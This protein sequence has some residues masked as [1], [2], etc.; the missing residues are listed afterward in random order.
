VNAAPGNIEH[1]VAYHNQIGKF[2]KR[3]TLHQ[4]EDLNATIHFADQYAQLNATNQAAIKQKLVQVVNNTP[5]NLEYLIAYHNQIGKFSKRLTI[6]QLEDLNATIQ[7]ADQYALLNATN[8]AA[9]KA[10]LVHYYAL[11][12]AGPRAATYMDSSFM[13]SMVGVPPLPDS[14]F[15]PQRYRGAYRGSRRSRGRGSH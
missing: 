2:S 11:T 4:L 15:Q 12:Q 9:I 3:L 5:D 7:F 14:F 1:L 6:H 8:Q 10:K 13:A